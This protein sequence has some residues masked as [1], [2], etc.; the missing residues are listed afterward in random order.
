MLDDSMAL[1]TIVIVYENQSTYKLNV[2][3]IASNDATEQSL[4][5][6]NDNKL[7]FL[8]VVCGQLAHTS[9]FS[10]IEWTMVAVIVS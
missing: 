9:L 10:A 1:Y 7:A 6:K 3:R 5:Y 8:Y 2:K 4:S